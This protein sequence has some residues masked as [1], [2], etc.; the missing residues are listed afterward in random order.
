MLI[1]INDYKHIW[2]GVF[3]IKLRYN[4]LTILKKIGGS[5]G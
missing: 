5:N 1:G 4:K 2:K 3:F